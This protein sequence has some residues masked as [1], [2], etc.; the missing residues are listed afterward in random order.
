MADALCIRARAADGAARFVVVSW[1]AGMYREEKAT[2][3][4]ALFLEWAGGRLEDLK[5]MKLMYLADRE[6]L[7]AWGKSIT[8][9]RYFSMKNGPVLS[10]TLDLMT[11]RDQDDPATVWREYIER[12][13]RYDIALKQPFRADAVLSQA[14]LEIVQRIWEAYGSWSKWDLVSLVHGFKEYT[15][16]SHPSVPIQTSSILQGLGLDDQTIRERVAN[17]EYHDAMDRLLDGTA[18]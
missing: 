15:P 12:P 5:L 9:D 8:G 11:P 3:V 17:I 13:E 6:S 16:T 18:R 7:R 1:E 10:T 2:A 14:E 4:A